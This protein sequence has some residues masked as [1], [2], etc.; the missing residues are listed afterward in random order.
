MLEERDRV[1]FFVAVGL[2]PSLKLVV[3]VGKTA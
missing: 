3:G 1:V 2:G